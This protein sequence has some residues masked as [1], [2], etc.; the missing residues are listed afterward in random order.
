[1]QEFQMANKQL[2][3]KNLT[4]RENTNKNETLFSDEILKIFCTTIST[5]SKDL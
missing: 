2:E 1:M 3:K 5:F 4:D